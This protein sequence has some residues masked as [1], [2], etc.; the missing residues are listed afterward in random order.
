M[1]F[2]DDVWASVSSATKLRV[3]DPFIGTFAVS[4]VVCNWNYIGLLLWGEDKVSA[5]INSFYQYI[6]E[7]S[8]FAFNSIFF[9]PF[10]FSIF[11]VLV[12]P[13]ITFVF[14]ALLKKANDKLH[15]QAVEIELDK[16]GQQEEL[17][18]ARLRSDP[19]KQFLEQSVKFEIDRKNEILEHLKHRTRRLIAWADASA[20]KL[21][22]AEAVAAEA[23]SKAHIAKLDEDS[24]SDQVR[25]EKM[26]F[27]VSSSRLKSAL[28][29]QRF[30]SVYFF[31]STIDESLKTDDV[32]L[33]LTGVG[34]VVAA[35]F[36]YKNFQ[37]IMEDEGFNNNAFSNV[38]YV[39]Y[40]SGRL[41]A[42]LEDIV[43]AE[44]SASED[45]TSEL[46]F[47]HIL[48]M[49]EELPYSFLDLDGLEEKCLEFF[50]DNKYSLLEHEGVSGAIAES[51]T[52]FD[53]VE[54]SV[55][56]SISFE[57]GFSAKIQAYS[58]GYHRRDISVP[59]RTMRIEMEI[60][61]FL[62]VGGRALGEFEFVTV[63]GGLDDF[64]ESE[65]EDIIE[66]ASML[67]SSPS[68]Q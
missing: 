31:M 35:I 9:V 38:E 42:R 50:E 21:A 43:S 66:A 2:L 40:D 7:A 55:V 26:R 29:S 47:D 53:G 46:L 41:A 16:V 34:E 8:F 36:G 62:Q 27:N 23:K 64:Y 68:S 12:F 49:F 56:K 11:Y 39:Y 58:K 45:L 10:A 32:R 6:S 14:K 25:L 48:M 51:D 60:K 13:W 20:V 63:S 61:S 59:G 15:R 37:L 44:S 5:R 18:K 17:N 67:P 1:K 54:L 65:D 57:R 24:K 52:I 33:S 4:W 30:P 28:A 22:E 3:S 19:D